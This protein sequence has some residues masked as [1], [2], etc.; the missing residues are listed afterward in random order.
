[1][2]PASY[3]ASCNMSCISAS[4]VPSV[5]SCTPK[6]R[7]TYAGPPPSAVAYGW[8]FGS[9]FKRPRNQVFLIDHNRSQNSK[10]VWIMLVPFCCI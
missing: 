4:A 7:A 8:A 6:L 10:L 2:G 1:M 3:F 9:S 5:T